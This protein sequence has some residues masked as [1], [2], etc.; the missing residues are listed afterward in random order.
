MTG[1]NLQPNEHN[2]NVARTTLDDAFDAAHSFAELSTVNQLVVVNIIPRIGESEKQYAERFLPDN[3]EAM[4][5][6][7]HN[8]TV[9]TY[10]GMFAN[11]L[12][13]TFFDKPI[14]IANFSVEAEGLNAS[15]ERAIMQLRS[16]RA[17][18]EVSYF[19]VVPEITF[20]IGGTNS[21]FVAETDFYHVFFKTH[22]FSSISKEITEESHKCLTEEPFNSSLTLASAKKLTLMPDLTKAQIKKITPLFIGYVKAHP[23][24]EGNPEIYE[25]LMSLF[26][27][28]ADGSQNGNQIFQRLQYLREDTDGKDTANNKALAELFNASVDFLYRSSKMT[29][30]VKY[31][32]DYMTTVYE[33]L[34]Y[35]PDLQ[36][37]I[38]S[39]VNQEPPQS[40]K[41]ALYYEPRALNFVI[42]LTNTS[43]NPNVILQQV[44]AFI[45]RSEKLKNLSLGGVLNKL[46]G[47]L[48]YVPEEVV[49]EADE[50]KAV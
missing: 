18:Y 12:I 32:D 8:R 23:I 27:L 31:F 44:L 40:N 34:N 14:S 22:F 48:P 3:F 13:K 28:F 25:G 37:A 39:R 4:K 33:F 10:E 30:F 24:P 20:S 1:T 29:G 26:R 5:K 15:T 36:I 19:E 42:K 7:V 21:N 16:I 41:H 2:P 46:E 45:K 9:A 38:S 35:A 43:D 47:F 50:P 6:M 17:L 11:A 49:L